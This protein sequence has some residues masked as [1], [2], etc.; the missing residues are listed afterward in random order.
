MAHSLLH[1]WILAIRPRTLPAGA[2]PVVL[3]ASL[4]F[5]ALPSSSRT[6]F[7]WAPAFAALTCAVLMQIATNLINDLYDFRRGVDTSDRLGPT[8]VVAAGLLSER[9][10]KAG[11]WLAV[12]LA[13]ILGQ[14]LVWV[15]GWQIFA[16]GV[17]SLLT[18]WAYTGGA[19]PLAYLGLGE[20]CAFIFFGVIPVSGTY[21]IQTGEWSFSSFLLSFSP[22]L[23]AANILLVNNIRDIATDARAGKRTLAVRIGSKKARLLYCW[24][25]AASLFMPLAYV[26]L[27]QKPLA[28]LSALAAPLVLKA[29]RAVLHLEGAAL[30]GLLAQTI[31][32]HIVHTSLLALGACLSAFVACAVR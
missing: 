10:V 18:A 24:A 16:I 1:S 5:A 3:G 32:V 7:L 11:A 13:F 15:G 12:I 2:A 8:R 27:E 14:Y 29:C 28:L 23:W 6:S 26:A 4:A 19:Y 20:V 9:A 21:F 25:S 22:A 31:R 17:A 30:N